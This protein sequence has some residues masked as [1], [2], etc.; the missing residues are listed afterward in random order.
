[1]KD[2]LTIWQPRQHIKLLARLTCLNRLVKKGQWMEEGN[3]QFTNRSLVK[4]SPKFCMSHGHMAI[5]SCVKEW[6]QL[7]NRTLRVRQK[8]LEQL[9]SKNLAQNSPNSCTVDRTDVPF[10]WQMLHWYVTTAP[11]KNNIYKNLDCCQTFCNRRK[12]WTRNPGKAKPGITD[13]TRAASGQLRMAPGGHGYFWSL[14][15]DWARRFLLNL[16]LA[17]SCSRR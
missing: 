17:I 9:I 2:R 11:L 13:T 6:F 3:T 4:R 8:D 7:S 1:M 14:E 15:S 10:Y 5:S 12:Q 16:K